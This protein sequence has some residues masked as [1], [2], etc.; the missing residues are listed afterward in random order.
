MYL[1]PF[2]E[3]PIE[4]YKEQESLRYK[5]DD[6][7]PDLV[8]GYYF[9]AGGMY[10]MGDANIVRVH[11]A[12]NCGIAIVDTLMSKDTI[13]P[14]DF[15]N[16]SIRTDHDDYALGKHTERFGFFGISTMSEDLEQQLA[17]IEQYQA[18]SQ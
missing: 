7:V 18:P 13:D 17:L 1:Q 6:L 16:P 4:T 10:L 15:T 12:T 3:I 8:V 14:F 11:P 2:R 5:I 9:S